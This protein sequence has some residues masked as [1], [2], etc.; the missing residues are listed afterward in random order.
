MNWSEL[1]QLLPNGFHDARLDGISINYRAR[2]AIFE[3]E[4]WAVTEWPENRPAEVPN[5]YRRGKL[6]FLGLL[7]CTLDV[8]NGEYQVPDACELWVNAAP[9]DSAVVEHSSWPKEP[10][11]EGAFRG[12]FYFLNDAASFVHVAAQDLDF[13]WLSASRLLDEAEAEPSA[14]N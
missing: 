8:P 7:A 14:A 10:L 3:L 11:P 13:E 6:T 5:L 9:V 4:L 2:T 1:E 12:V